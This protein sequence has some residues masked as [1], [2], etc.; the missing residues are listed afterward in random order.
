MIKL[1]DAEI[2]V[3]RVSQIIDR[4]QIFAFSNNAQTFQ[5]IK[6]HCDVDRGSRQSSNKIR[7]VIRWKEERN[8]NERRTEHVT[9]QIASLPAK[10]ADPFRSAVQRQEITQSHGRM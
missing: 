1:Y 5:A 8:G 2:S 7:D 4:R 6:T 10:D 9:T 3:H